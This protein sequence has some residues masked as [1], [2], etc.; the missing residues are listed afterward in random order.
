MSA[1]PSMDITDFRKNWTSVQDRVRAQQVIRITKHGKDAF[2]VVDIDYLQAVLETIEIMS[3]PESHRLLLESLEDVK[4]G[5][6]IDHDEVKRR[7]L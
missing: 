5:R 4:N 1:M 2:A 6:V 7:L 3:D